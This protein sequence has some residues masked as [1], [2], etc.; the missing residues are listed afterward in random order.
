MPCL[1]TSIF[2]CDSPIPV[3][4]WECNLQL[5]VLLRRFFHFYSYEF[6]WGS[7]VVAVH[8][9]QRLG[10]SGP[11][12]TQLPGR[13]RARLHIQDPFLTERNLNCTLQ[14]G[15]ELLLRT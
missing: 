4:S 15:Q 8:L 12:F 2:N 5:P 1:P 11:Q 10:V 9:G 14:I 7:E 6:V 3:E 13:H